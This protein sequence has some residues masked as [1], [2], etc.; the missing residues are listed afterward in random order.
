MLQAIKNWF[1]GKKAPV[2][3]IEGIPTDFI[4]RFNAAL[5]IVTPIR[6]EFDRCALFSEYSFELF[7]QCCKELYDADVDP[8]IQK[9]LV[10]RMWMKIAKETN[11]DNRGMA[12]IDDFLKTSKQWHYKLMGHM[13]AST[14]HP[15]RYFLYAFIIDQSFMYA[16]EMIQQIAEATETHDV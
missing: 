5:A 3:N 2:N 9:T 6:D 15:S 14:E 4:E 13:S 11:T 8:N 16:I 12:S 1:K 10:G 7:I